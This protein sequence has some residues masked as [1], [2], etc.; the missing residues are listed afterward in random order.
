MQAIVGARCLRADLL[1]SAAAEQ[2]AKAY[3]AVLGMEPP[4]GDVQCAIDGLASM[5]KETT[6]TDPP[7]CQCVAC[8]P[9]TTNPNPPDEPPT[10][11]PDEPPQGPDP[12]PVDDDAEDS[13]AN[14]SGGDRKRE[15]KPS[16]DDGEE[17][18]KPRPER[19]CHGKGSR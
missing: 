17:G 6:A 16:R 13:G 11:P 19:T 7:A 5:K 2:A 9:P 10:T 14:P 4:M 3:T 15:Q 12:P 1:V 18:D 8:S